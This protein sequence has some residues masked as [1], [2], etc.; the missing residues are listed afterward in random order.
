MDGPKNLIIL[1]I[2]QNIR[3]NKQNQQTKKIER[4]QNANNDYHL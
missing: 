4:V 1:M 3:F 2:S